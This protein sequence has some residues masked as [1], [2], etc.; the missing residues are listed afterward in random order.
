MLAL[1]TVCDGTSVITE[2]LFESRFKHVAE[3]KK[4]GANITVKDRMAIVEGVPKLYG[5][6]VFAED[7]R[8]GASL[9]LAGLVADGYTEVNNVKHIDRGYY[10]IEND[11]ASL[12]AKIE[13]IE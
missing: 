3:L 12:G 2:N 1:Q 10:K 13:R 7:L 8:G 6:E 11:L 4:M 5:A 9:V